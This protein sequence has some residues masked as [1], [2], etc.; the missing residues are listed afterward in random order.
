MKVK[1][2][3]GLSH[4][5][6][7]IGV[8]FGDERAHL[9]IVTQVPLQVVGLGSVEYP[10]GTVVGGE[11]RRPSD[12]AAAVDEAL[13]RMY[14][15]TRPQLRATVGV[16]DLHDRST[17]R[18]A[19]T[20]PV[21]DGVAVGETGAAQRVVDSVV[22]TVAKST[23]ADPTVASVDATPV[24]VAR[25]L[26]ASGVTGMVFAR[27]FVGSSRWTLCDDGNRFETEV[28]R[29]GMTPSA[30]VAGP[31]QTRLE[32]PAWG[33]IPVAPPILI[34]HR[35]PGWFVPAVGAALAAAGFTPTGDLVGP[36]STRAEIDDFY[37]EWNLEQVR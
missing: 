32:P 13:A 19:V 25:M 16:S 11:V 9:A 29:P 37:T 34:E 2:W 26:R 27:G 30:V 24:A 20:T 6:R 7:S 28:E 23:V 8:E 1:R 12:A 4:D 33:A 10:A 14:W 35:F 18:V 15:P 22:A 36:W 31:E 17:A 3:L 21:M 5:V